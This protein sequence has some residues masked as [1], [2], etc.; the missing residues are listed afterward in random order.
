[1]LAKEKEVRNKECTI[2]ALKSQLSYMQRECREAEEAKLEAERLR[3]QLDRL[4]K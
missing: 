3:N 4:K 2:S 1:M